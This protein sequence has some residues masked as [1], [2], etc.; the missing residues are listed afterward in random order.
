M[1]AASKL[2]WFAEFR[3]AGVRGIVLYSEDGAQRAGVL[4]PLAVLTLAGV[5]G[6]VATVG[7]SRRVLGVVLVLAGSAACWAA[8]RGLPLSGHADGLPVAQMLIG[9]GLAMFGGILVIAGGLAGIRD[10]GRMP[11]LGARYS[12]PAATR[13]ARDPDTDLWEALSDG[14]DPTA[15]R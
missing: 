3:D 1:W 11:H 7:W 15:K 12:A 8:V 2:T 6:M 13:M 4:V 10:A 9:R 5:A 14:E